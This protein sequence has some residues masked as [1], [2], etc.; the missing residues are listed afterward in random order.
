MPLRDGTKELATNDV[1][2]SAPTANR[3]DPD[4]TSR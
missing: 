3:T 2:A 1:W 4:D